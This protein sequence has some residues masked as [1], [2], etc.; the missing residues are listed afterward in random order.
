M[1]QTNFLI[2]RGE[3][4][5]GEIKAPKRGAKKAEVYSL[6]EALS[7]LN[8][9]VVATADAL[10]SLPPEA[11]PGD[12]GVA[13]LT[14]NPG[15]IAKS[16]FPG[17]VLRAMDLKS[18]GSRSV[19][20]HP[21]KWSRKG[22]PEETQSIELFVA[23]KRKSFQNFSEWCSSL[24]EGQ[25]V[26]IEF[27]RIESVSVFSPEERI[28]HLGEAENSTYEIGIHLVPDE[29]HRFVQD[30]FIEYAHANDVRVFRQYRFTAGNLWFVPVAGSR[31]NI[32]KL[33]MFV[34][35]R[36]IRPMPRLRSVRPMHRSGGPLIGCRL[37]VE[38]ALSSEVK[39]AI[40]DGGL[41]DEHAIGPW[42][43]DLRRLNEDA[44]DDID[45]VEHGLAVTSA[46]LFGP[47]SPNGVAERP[48]ANVDHLR[49]L[50]RST[51][52]V[53][54]DPLE[55]YRTLD[56]IE[57]VL[58]AKNYEFLNLSLGPELSVDDSDVHAWTSV[59]DG[60]LSDGD[61]F[62]TVAAG[63]NGALDRESGNARIQVPADCVNALAIG[64]ADKSS[65]NWRRSS[66]SA[67]GP[68]RRPGVVKPDLMAFGG[69]ASS[70]FHVLSKGNRPSVYPTLG[71]SFASP[72]A[73]RNA[74]GI[75]AILGNDLPALAIKALLVHAA[76][77]ST[78]DK[79]EVGWGKIPE[80]LMDII[81]CPPGVA[82][83]VYKGSLRPGKYL[84][85]K[86]P[87][88]AGGIAGMVNLKATFCIA[89]KTDPQDASA[90]TRAGLDVVFRPDSSRV[91]DGRETAKTRPFFKSKSYATEQEQRHDLSKWETVLHG[92]ERMRG[93][94][95][96][97]PVFDIHYNAREFAGQAS[98]A[99]IIHYALI[100]TLEASRHPDLYNDVLRTYSNIL[101]P[102]QPRISLPIRT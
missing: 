5:A 73:L 11:C 61:V 2:G 40:L 16:Y 87:I 39:V 77:P 81:T 80:N 9:Q 96:T 55:L 68:G 53:D 1:S 97:N 89:S 49:V 37:P 12:Y 93:A 22:S 98:D 24:R 35:V 78:H 26:S 36:V 4:L 33:S 42:L 31:E 29:D 6:S 101:T 32:A 52:R 102:L 10:D 67:I 28:V 50:D 59:I 76:D 3:Y 69:D 99:D 100:I 72:Y 25:N 47:I 60:Y 20:I 88:P 27:A 48:Y 86:L 15:Y 54:E 18:V 85:A 58:L 71:T 57:N 14:M 62:L 82:R 63:N 56:L 91:L 17:G 30:A 7:R 75:R 34:F 23:G 51:G 45:G 95:L 94:K 84:R 41:P 8:P 74:V 65:D 38:Q 19:S 21:D 92:E 79:L 66:Y 13:K 83:V 90:Y 70:Y 44:E 64:S 46:F 43:R